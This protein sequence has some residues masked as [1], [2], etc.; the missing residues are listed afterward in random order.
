MCH[1]PPKSLLGLED[2][3]APAPGSAPAGGTP[4]RCRRCRRRRSARRRARRCRS[5][6]VRVWLL[7]RLILDLPSWPDPCPSDRWSFAEVVYPADNRSHRSTDVTMSRWSNGAVRDRGGDERGG[8]ERGGARGGAREGEEREGAGGEDVVTGWT[9]PECGRLFGRSGQSHDCAPGLVARGVLLDRSVARASRVRRGDGSRRHPR[10]RPRRHRLGRHL[11]QE[12][13]Q[14]RRVAADAALGGGVV[15]PEPFG[16]AS[17]DHPSVWSSTTIGSG[18]SPM[19]ATPDQVD[20]ALRSLLTEAYRD[21][22][23]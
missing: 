5:P 8:D 16:V 6:C 11:P 14:V 7:V 19:S 12:P 4:R 10:T 21:A 20:D 1:V 13:T 17:H 3:E 2:D 9:C 18:T 23:P 15:R 22:A